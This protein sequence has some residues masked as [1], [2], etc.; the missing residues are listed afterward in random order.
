MKLLVTQLKEGENSFQF[1][2][3]KDGWVKV[4]LQHVEKQGYHV[5]GTMRIDMRLTK[6]EPDYYLKG[7][8]GFEIMQPCARCAESFPMNVRH[9]FD[10]ALAHVASTRVKRVDVAE[11]SDELDVNFIEGDEIDFS[12]IV[13]EQFFLS[14][15]YQSVCRN[16][17]KGICQFCGKNLNAGDCK[18]SKTD[19]VHPFGVLHGLKI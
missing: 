19:P 11:E 13:E 4:V 6:L 7:Q 14:I 16:D 9:N 15:P 3:V 8:L 10:V 12:P 2:S 5:H 1:D 17:C 18:C